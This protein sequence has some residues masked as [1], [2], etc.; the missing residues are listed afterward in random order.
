[1]HYALAGIMLAAS[2]LRA[3]GMSVANRSEERAFRFDV[4]QSQSVTCAG[5]PPLVQISPHDG[6]LKPFYIARHEL[7]WAEYIPAVLENGC[8]LP[9]LPDGQSYPRDLSTIADTFPVTRLPVPKLRCF[10]DWLKAK[11]GHAYRLP[12]SSEWEYAARAGTRTR[13]PWGDH[14]GRNFAALYGYFDRD[15]QPSSRLTSDPR[16]ALLRML[17]PVESFPANNFG[18]YDMVG[19][20]REFVMK[21]GRGIENCYRHRGPDYCDVQV[22]RGGGTTSSIGDNDISLLVKEERWVAGAPNDVSFRLVRE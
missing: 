19:N 12:T 14:P 13:F 8:P 22:S 17:V 21:T 15:L 18:L 10:L 2:L 1:M 20:A 9:S 7:T 4:S 11:T 16:S 6:N 5:C 3:D